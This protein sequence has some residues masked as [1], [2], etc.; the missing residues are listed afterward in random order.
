MSFLQCLI[1]S[2]IMQVSHTIITLTQ[3]RRNYTAKYTRTTNIK[4]YIQYA[5][6]KQN[7]KT[8]NYIITYII[9]LT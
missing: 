2:Y 1:L 6:C 9:I 5:I 7:L 4:F 8:Y 3:A